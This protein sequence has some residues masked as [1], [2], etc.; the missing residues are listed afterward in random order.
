MSW[1]LFGGAAIIVAGLLLKAGAPLIAVLAG[2]VLA[3]LVNWQRQRAS[4]GPRN[5]SA[6]AR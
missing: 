5:G 6:S 4:R 3:G 1:R 2:L